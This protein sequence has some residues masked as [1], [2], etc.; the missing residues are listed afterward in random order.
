MALHDDNIYFVGN[1]SDDKNRA[2]F[3]E[4]IGHDGVDIVGPEIILR[5]FGQFANSSKWK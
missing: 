5:K 4:I 1:K 3:K 2:I